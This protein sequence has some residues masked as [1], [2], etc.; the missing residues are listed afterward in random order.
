MNPI[1]SKNKLFLLLVVSITLML[2]D[3]ALAALNEG[4]PVELMN[5]FKSACLK[6]YHGIEFYALL[7]LWALAGIEFAWASTKNVIEG[8]GEIQKTLTLLIQAIIRPGFATL[9]IHK[10]AEWL[11]AIVES[12]KFFAIKGTGFTDELNPITIF[13][14]GVVLQNQMVA[15]FNSEIGS[16]AYAAISNFLPALLMFGV[17]IIILLAFGLM[18][19]TFAL[20]VIESY[21]LLAVSPTLFAMA[22][23]RWTKDIALKPWNSMIAV[24]MKIM[25]MMLVLSIFVQLAPA[26]AKLVS[27]FTITDWSPLWWTACAAMTAGVIAWKVPTIASNALTGTASL[28]AGDAIQ[29][30][31]IAIA[32]AVGATAAT[33]QMAMG[34]ARAMGGAAGKV[35]SAANSLGIGGR[36]N[37]LEQMGGNKSPMP[38]SAIPDPN[39]PPPSGNGS[40]SNASIGSNNVS[41]ETQSKLDK[42]FGKGDQK[43]AL[44]HVRGAF[45]TLARS[46][47]NDQATVGGDLIKN[48]D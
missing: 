36:A 33:G 44:G 3:L 41:P 8:G 47:P 29:M 9:F 20:T 12:F 30:A 26:L 37:T 19:I 48:S 14:M 34:G 43:G 15:Q 32:G 25:I 40:A 4:T 2:P 42:I 10:G 28:S 11:P 46:V 17:C 45:D 24:G 23:S 27:K 7:L 5:E 16:G 18:A 31:A 13:D 1:F 39:G 22:G 38:A 21:I 6:F 35:K